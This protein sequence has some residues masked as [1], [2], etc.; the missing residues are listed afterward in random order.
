MA[1]TIIYFDRQGMP[2]LGQWTVCQDKDTTKASIRTNNID[3]ANLLIPF[4]WAIADFKNNEATPT[5]YVPNRVYALDTAILKPT[6]EGLMPI[7]ENID[8]L[9]KFET[10]SQQTTAVSH[11]AAQYHCAPTCHYIYPPDSCGQY[12]PT[13]VSSSP[14]CQYRGSGIMEALPHGV[15]GVQGYVDINIKSESAFEYLD[16]RIS[17]WPRDYT[18]VS[19]VMIAEHDAMGWPPGESPGEIFNYRSLGNNVF[20]IY[21]WPGGGNNGKWG[22]AGTDVTIRVVFTLMGG[23]GVTT[24]WYGDFPETTR[25]VEVSYVGAGRRGNHR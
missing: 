2:I 5:I 10:A 17:D 25:S 15:R 7:P 3:T 23:Y 11:W 19:G 18:I 14:Q 8:G 22:P 12:N 1:D 9:C 4:D 6:I 24:I 21:A 20:R 16:I 13:R